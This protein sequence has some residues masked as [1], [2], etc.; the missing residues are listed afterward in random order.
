MPTRTKSAS[1]T[2]MLWTKDGYKNRQVDQAEQHGA[3]TEQPRDAP[4]LRRWHHRD[5]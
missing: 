3:Q 4:G 1:P 2:A 5:R